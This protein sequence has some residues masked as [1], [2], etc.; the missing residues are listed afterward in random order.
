MEVYVIATL[1]DLRTHWDE[2]SQWLLNQDAVKSVKVKGLKLVD[3][4][5]CLNLG[6][7]LEGPSEDV[8]RFVERLTLTLMPARYAPA[9][10]APWEGVIP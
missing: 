4:P 3:G 8:K 1:K 7:C 5:G 9:K 6:L 2:I 10:D